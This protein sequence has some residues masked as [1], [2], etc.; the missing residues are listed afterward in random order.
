SNAIVRKALQVLINLLH[1]GAKGC[2]VN[3]GDG[4][5]ILLQVPHEFLKSEAMK[6]GIT[7][8]EPGKY[9][10]GMVGLPRDAASRR[11][12]EEQF[13]AAV[14]RTGQTVLGWRDVPTDH[15]PIGNSAKAVEPV[16]RQIFIAADPRISG[17]VEFE[18]KLFL[19]RKR[20]E[21]AVA[22][23]DIPERTYF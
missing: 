9:G 20:A 19:I 17:P 12:C 1:R 6:L 16:F 10:V 3:T 22:N 2:E 23:S 7:L 5:G 8:P 18:R 13:E 4:A 14:V 11:G 15:S 21:T